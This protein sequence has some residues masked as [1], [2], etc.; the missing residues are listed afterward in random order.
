MQT[1]YNHIISALLKWKRNNL[2]SV[3][4]TLLVVKKV[5]LPSFWS[6][7]SSLQ[8][9]MNKYVHVQF[10]RGLAL[11]NNVQDRVRQGAEAVC[12]FFSSPVPFSEDCGH[13]MTAAQHNAENSENILVLQAWQEHCMTYCAQ[14]QEQYDEHIYVLHCTICNQ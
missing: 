6:L 8:S 5:L 9:H 12:Y 11:L 10:L 2:N 13:M 7:A 14:Q 1:S 4:S 3:Y